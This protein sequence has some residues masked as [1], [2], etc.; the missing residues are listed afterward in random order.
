M[1]SELSPLAIMELARLQSA[2]R[3]N[4]SHD[5]NLLRNAE[6]LAADRRREPAIRRRL[7]RYAQI[8][9]G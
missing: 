5:L 7:E 4:R 6:Y 1:S 8:L 9:A 2:A 3:A